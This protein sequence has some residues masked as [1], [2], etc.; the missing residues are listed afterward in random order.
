M[1]VGN[2]HRKRKAGDEWDQVGGSNTRS[3]VKGSQS[4]GHT[5]TSSPGGF[6]VGAVPKLHIL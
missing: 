5:E 4:K 2:H 6:D 1:Q 3:S